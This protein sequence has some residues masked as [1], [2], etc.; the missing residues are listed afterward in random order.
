MSD[1]YFA[2]L[3]IPNL[4]RRLLAEG[5]LN[6]A[7]VPMWL[8]LRE[9]QGPDAARRFGERVFGTMFLSLGV[10]TLLCMV[11]APVT[12][13]LIAPGFRA[14]GERYYYAV[15]FIR[16]SAPYV[17]VAGL[18]AVAASILNAEGRVGA[19]AGGL[20]IFNAVLVSAVLVVVLLGSN[21]G[22]A[23]DILSLAIVLAGVGQ[24]IIVGGALLRSPQ[25]PRR[26]SFTLS[27]EARRFYARA[28]PGVIAGGIPQLKLMAGAM[29]ASASPAA[30]SWLYYANRLYELPLGVVSVAIASVLAPRIASSV[31]ASDRDGI[32][33]AQ[34]RAFEIA[35]GLALP[36]AIA[37]ATLAMPI[38][39]GLFERGAFGPN[40]TIAVASALVA[41]SAGLPGHILEKV[42]AG[43]SFAHDDT[44]TPMFAALAGLTVA[45]T[46]AILLFPDYGHVGIAAA[47]AISGWVGATLL[48][49]ILWRRG[50]LAISHSTWRRIAII[51]L[52]SAVMGI[53]ILGGYLLIDKNFAASD[54]ALGRIAT[55]ATMVATGLVT[56]LICL[57]VL[58]IARMKDLITAVNDR[59]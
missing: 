16:L 3:Q 56:Y 23:G 11:F 58:G 24:F 17:T 37:F 28:I 34:S 41:I 2:A 15:E 8:R 5:A 31:L 47:I 49:V 29:V 7:F 35:L 45:T 32:A 25:R 20:V 1:A 12:I 27:A 42:L 46:M 6:A 9:E 55:L 10:I 51:V 57:Q 40:D 54:T 52:A 48:S 33:A 50:W 22:V 18:V 36:S 4:F 19:V 21:S 59:F 44:R 43:I 39:G 38:A 14:D 53:V 13:H 30:V 26:I